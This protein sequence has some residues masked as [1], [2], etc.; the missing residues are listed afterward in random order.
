MTLDLNWSRVFDYENV[1]EMID[2]ETGRRSS[3]PKVYVLGVL[4]MHVGINH[5]THDNAAEF[6]TRIK[7][8]EA[9][10]GGGL[11]Q[12]NKGKLV[13]ITAEDV[14][15]HVGLTSNVST[16]TTMQFYKHLRDDV[17]KELRRHYKHASDKRQAEI[18]A[19]VL[20]SV[21]GDPEL[22]RLTAE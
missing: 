12:D 22:R 18:K 11:M 13:G 15:N 5:L 7:L 2:P 8:I 6:Y 16:Y 21:Q 14:Y 10:F 4:M 1:C 3:T 9:C 19:K 20:E 17:V